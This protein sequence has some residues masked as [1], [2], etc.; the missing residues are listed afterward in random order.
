MN[1]NKMK[2][3]TIVLINGEPCGLTGKPKRAIDGTWIVF[4]QN[5]ATGEN[6]YVYLTDA[7][8]ADAAAT[9]K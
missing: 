6:S 8:L 9:S 7:E 2:R 1:L 4:H 5:L 3:G